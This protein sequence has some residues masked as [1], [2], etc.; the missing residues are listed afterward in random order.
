MN[1]EQQT[2]PA[3][4]AL[5]A[6]FADVAP[7][8]HVDTSGVVRA[9]RRGRTARVWTGVGVGTVLLLAPAAVIIGGSPFVT[10]D[11][12]PAGHGLP[13]PA[14]SVVSDRT[15]D[16]MTAGDG[17]LRTALVSG[18]LFVTAHD[19]LALTRGTEVLALVLPD[20]WQATIDGSGAVALKNPSGENVA[21]EGDLVAGTGGIVEADADHAW[22]DHPCAV[23]N[24]AVIGDVHLAPE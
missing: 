8:I 19:C 22:Q 11:T 18:R 15:V 9:A 21:Q 14:P 3:A 10:G 1:S 13:E 20:G 23:G 4:E 17:P 7:T 6:R 16:W 5:R 24:L 12:E 2:D